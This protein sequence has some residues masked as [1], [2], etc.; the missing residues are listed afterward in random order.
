[1]SAGLDDVDPAQAVAGLTAAVDALLA[2]RLGSLPLAAL[3]EL[4]RAV[5]TQLRRMPTFDHAWIT[6][7]D[8]RDA[9]TELG[10]K[11]VA[12][13]LVD[14]LRVT[15]GHARARVTAAANLGPR[16]GST[17]EVLPA[18]FPLVVAA[19]TA[20]AISTEPAQVVT[21]P[22]PRGGTN[23]HNLTLV[24]GYHREFERQGWTCHLNNGVPW[25]TP[26]GPHPP[27]STQIE[28]PA[29]TTPAT[30]NDSYPTSHRP[31]NTAPDHAPKTSSPTPAKPENPP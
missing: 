20:D 11:S 22:G 1:M 30:S 21:P 3:P 5:E 10:A 2:L 23:L 12:A 31:E 18:L 16:Y 7:L 29:E 17:G 9:P 4:G 25:W 19:H 27:G 26:P 13:I 6:E 14:T 8:R 28:P 24:C 15:P